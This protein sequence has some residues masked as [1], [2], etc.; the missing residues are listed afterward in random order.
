[1]LYFYYRDWLIVKTLKF[2]DTL[3]NTKRYKAF[4]VAICRAAVMFLWEKEM[5][6]E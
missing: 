5:N 6:Y 1:M 4:W 3:I 2:S